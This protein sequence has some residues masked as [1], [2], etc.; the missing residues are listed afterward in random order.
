MS[1]DHQLNLQG[2]LRRGLA[3]VAMEPL[4]DASFVRVFIR[5]SVPVLIA[6]T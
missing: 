2:P 4:R 5:P 1:N 3:A 6:A